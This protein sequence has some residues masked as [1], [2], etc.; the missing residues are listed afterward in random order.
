MDLQFERIQS[1]SHWHLQDLLDLYVE[2]F[3]NEERRTTSELLRMLNVQ[4]MYFTA[5]LVEEVVVGFVVYWKFGQFRYIEHLAIYPAHR[6]KGFGAGVLQHLQREGKP[7]L[8]EV[9]IPQD[10]LST[11][12]VGFYN[13]AGFNALPVYYHQ[14]P[15]RKGE[16]LVPMLLFS[17][18]TDWDDEL[19]KVSTEQFQEKVY[20]KENKN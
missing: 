17:D 11:Q 3:P 16:S 7:L 13:R 5:V 2:S 19:L 6:R 4:E 14:P 12:R 20:F 8:L 1:G 15:Y 9:E 18:R 10:V